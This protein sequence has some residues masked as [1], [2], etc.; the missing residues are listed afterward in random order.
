MTCNSQ[1]LLFTTDFCILGF[2][3]WIQESEEELKSYCTFIS[4]G[5]IGCIVPSTRR[6]QTCTPRMSLILL[7][8]SL[9]KHLLII[10]RML[11]R[12]FRLTWQARRNVVLKQDQTSNMTR[13]ANTGIWILRFIN[14]CQVRI[15]ILR[16]APSSILVIVMLALLAQKVKI[17]I[18]VGFLKIL[19]MGNRKQVQWW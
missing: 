5:I 2:T 7:L 18:L 13:P 12:R 6:A 15:I 8:I 1:L 11:L 9:T 4:I 3:V 14:N 19:I 17:N 10:V 16:G